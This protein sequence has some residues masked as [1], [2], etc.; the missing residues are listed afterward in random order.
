LRD[1]RNS[2]SV[3]SG[4]FGQSEKKIGGNLVLQHNSGFITDEESLF[5]HGAYFRSDIVENV[6]HCW[7][8]QGIFQITDTKDRNPIVDADIGI[9]IKKLSKGSIYVFAEF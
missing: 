2:E 8:F 9:V 3:F 7:C 6:E 1:S 5:F 4:S